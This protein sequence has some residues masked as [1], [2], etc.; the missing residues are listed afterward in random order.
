VFFAALVGVVNLVL[1]EA[2]RGSAI[3]ALQTSIPS[4]CS[5]A[6]AQTC[7]SELLGRGIPFEVVLPI[8]ISGLLFGTLYGMYYEYLPGV[9]YRIRAAAMGIAMLLILLLFGLAGIAIDLATRLALNGV[10]LAA[11]IGYDL[12]IAHFYR[13]FTREVRFEGPGGDKLKFTVDSKNFAG[14]TKTLS[15]HSTHKVKAADGG[16]FHGW[17]A[18]G[19]VTVLDPKS[20]ETTITV[21]GDGLLK[22]S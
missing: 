11:M 17:L 14:K 8:G 5:G 22:I 18:S 19:G 13:R 16:R 1:L 10:D 21:G 7:F 9:G 12:I 3:A 20:P 4:T 2:V 6:A 15:L